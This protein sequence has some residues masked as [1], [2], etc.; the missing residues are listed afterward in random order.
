VRIR[1]GKICDRTL[2]TYQVQNKPNLDNIFKSYLCYHNLESLHNSPHY[3]ER[4]PKT[5]FAMVHQLGFPTFI[6]TFTYTKRLWD[7]FI[8]TLH[9]LHVSRLKLSNKI[10]NFQLVHIT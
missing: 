5:L 2:K 3:F 6:V 8:K 7:F 1:K 9:T 10:K 4:L